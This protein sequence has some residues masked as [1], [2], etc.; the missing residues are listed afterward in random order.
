MSTEYRH[1]LERPRVTT[2]DAYRMYL[3]WANLGREMTARPL[4]LASAAGWRMAD[5]TARGLLGSRS[6][7][8]V[9]AGLAQEWLD[10][11][12]ELLTL[13]A[14][15]A[16]SVAARLDAPTE[17]GLGPLEPAL[18]GARPPGTVTRVELDYAVA[19]AQRRDLAA[20]AGLDRDDPILE[21]PPML[22]G[23]PFLLPAR[24]LDASQAWAVWFVPLDQAQQLLH[25]SVEFGHQPPAVV[26]AFTPVTVGPKLAMVSLLASDYRASDFGVT[27]EIALTLAVSP[28][29]GSVVDPG[30][31]FLRLIVTDPY[32]IAA[33]RQIWGIRKD[34]WDNTREA[35]TFSQ[36]AV[37]Y[38]ADRVR[39][40]VGAIRPS[41]VVRPRT[42]EL[43]FPR[44]GA[45][46]SDRVPSVIYSMVEPH[47]LPAA[48]PAAARS[49][50]RR[51]G[52][53]EGMQ[54]RGGVTLDLPENSEQGRREGC[55]CSGG[56][57]CLCETLR[58]LG[59]DSRPPAANGWTEYMT[60]DLHEP[61]LLRGQD[62]GNR[63]A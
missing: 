29:G 54:F 59:L 10:L 20:R 40:R 45:G 38:A 47:G 37:G 28:A 41:T 53:R 55:L 61:A 14:S 8:D 44:F 56:M 9:A 51:S 25:E 46:R 3:A 63:P 36:I 1:A 57:A 60:C 27:Q 12:S 31:M 21:M 33:A 35:E 19:E 6:S 42:L 5:R 22:Y 7:A 32:S 26:D 18:S 30:Q 43:A 17:P 48:P 4:A 24:V 23:A 16:A 62:S 15:A 50:L 13:P 2:L 34:F 58:G 52:T 11:A 49:V 39:F